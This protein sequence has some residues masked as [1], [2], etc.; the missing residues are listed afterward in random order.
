M[1]L[2]Q[3][4]KNDIVATLMARAFDERRRAMDV[5]EQAV[6]L[7]VYRGVVSEE[8]E[9]VADDLNKRIPSIVYTTKTVRFRVLTGVAQKYEGHHFVLAQQRAYTMNN[10][11]T[12][13]FSKD[14]EIATLVGALVQD[15]ENYF[16]EYNAT[17]RKAKGALASINTDTQL[18]RLWPDIMPIVR[19]ILSANVPKTPPAI[20]IADLNAV[21]GL[22]IE[23]KEA[24]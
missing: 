24:A 13:T 6:A 18:E 2:N 3:E 7:L 23:V 15:R 8:V 9:K 1:R 19:E 17:F 16:E 22:P 20:P 10:S 4:I 5:R 11:D 21:F 12:P 14:S